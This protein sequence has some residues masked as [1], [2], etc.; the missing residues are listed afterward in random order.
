MRFLS[1][2]LYFC[3]QFYKFLN[4]LGAACCNGGF[5]P[6]KRHGLSLTVEA[7]SAGLLNYQKPCGIVPKRGAQLKI[8]A[9]PAGRGGAQV[10]S[11]RALTA[12]IQR[13]EETLLHKLKAL[14]CKLC[15]IGGS[16]AADKGSG[17]LCIGGVDGLAV[18]K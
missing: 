18:K 16:A 15:E 8:Q 12:N 14:V 9:C 2:I 1:L 3:C 4:G 10:K 6:V 5:A 7:E 11:G 13:D 17:K